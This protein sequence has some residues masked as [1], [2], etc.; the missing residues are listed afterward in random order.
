MIEDSKKIMFDLRNALISAAR[1]VNDN[2]GKDMSEL[3][4]KYKVEDGDTARTIIDKYAEKRMH[5][6][7]SP[8]YPNAVYNLEETDVDQAASLEG[9]LL[10]F[11]DPFDGTANAQPKLPLSTQG[12]IAAQGNEFIA[13][14]GL[15]PF[16]KYVLYGAKGQGVFR[17]ELAIDSDGNYYLLGSTERKLPSLEDTFKKVKSGEHIL[18]PFVDA[19][20]TPVNFVTQRKT[21][22]KSLFVE[23]FDS[24]CGG[25]FKNASMMRE[26]GSNIDTGMKVAEGRLHVGLTD[27]IGGIY[28][29]AVG[30]VLISELGGVVTDM[31]GEELK[32]PTNPA[33][34][35]TPVQQLIV[36]SISPELHP[37][38]LKI[39]KACYGEDSQIYIPSKDALLRVPKYTGFKDWN[40]KDKAVFD[41]LFKR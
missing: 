10:I 22:W 5:D 18:M 9:K 36:A 26:M 20:Y 2:F 13:A 7:L 39:T 17:S 41:S 27:T 19:H 33:E 11:G 25:K 35:K 29:V 24:R 28:D 3:G 37:D 12:L 4:A 40:P 23:I 38:V 30:D 8:I 14:A 21:K 1:V 16:E 32:V 15:H 34:M 6:H 31:D